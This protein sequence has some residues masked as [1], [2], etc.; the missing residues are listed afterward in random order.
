M[1]ADAWRRK[2]AVL[3]DIADVPQPADVDYVRAIAGAVQDWSV[4]EFAW[5]MCAAWP[6]KVGSVFF[7]R[8]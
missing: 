8:F 6:V 7:P 3:T 5:S 4:G 1:V 2:Q